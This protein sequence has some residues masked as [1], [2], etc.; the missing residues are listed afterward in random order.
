MSGWNLDIDVTDTAASDERLFLTLQAAP[1]A[2]VSLAH[3]FTVAMHDA[4]PGSQVTF[5]TDSL[6]APCSGNPSR[7]DY[8]YD[9]AALAKAVDFLV[10]MM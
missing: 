10:V 4:V 1:S 8:I 3:R 5:D 2:M 6:A 7:P 9:V